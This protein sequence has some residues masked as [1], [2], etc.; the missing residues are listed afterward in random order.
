MFLIPAVRH[1]EVATGKPVFLVVSWTI[2]NHVNMC[3]TSEGLSL[4]LLYN[5]AYCKTHISA[6]LAKQ[7]V[8]LDLC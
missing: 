1:K 6:S 8:E 4:S 2:A 5:V 7:S 3:G